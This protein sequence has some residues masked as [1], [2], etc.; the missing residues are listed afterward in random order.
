M[1]KKIEK[2]L[3]TVLFS[4][5]SCLAFTVAA[6]LYNLWMIFILNPFEIALTHFIR[7]D[8]YANFHILLIWAFLTGA[9]VFFNMTRTYKRGKLSKPF[10]YVSKFLM[11]LALVGLAVSVVL[12]PQAY[13]DIH[14]VGSLA[15]AFG[16]IASVVAAFIGAAVK[17]IN[18][19]FLLAFFA[20]IIY[21]CFLFLFVLRQMAAW[22]ILPL[23]CSLFMML[24]WNFTDLFITKDK[25]A[26][27]IKKEFSFRKIPANGL[28]GMFALVAAVVIDF[29]Y[30]EIGASFL[31]SLVSLGRQ[32]A[33]GIWDFEFVW[34]LVTGVAVI[35]ALY[36]FSY[37]S[38]SVSRGFF[39]EIFILV[40]L[41]VLVLACREAWLIWHSG[42]GVQSVYLMY[43]RSFTILSFGILA[44]RL[45]NLSF[46]NI[47]YTAITAAYLFTVALHVVDVVVIKDFPLGENLPILSFLTLL[48]LINYTETF[49]VTSRSAQKERTFAEKDLLVRDT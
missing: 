17:N 24:I 32:G 39:M 33:Y 7:D 48:T 44:F 6:L 38:R 13:D 28:F 14:V 46:K 45:L 1:D 31:P 15:F 11:Y 4:D 37:R 41:A 26:P 47:K 27:K 3:K 49:D 8:N 35:T 9:A 10:L 25:N 29:L 22:E 30:V 20:F 40:D 21:H 34:R 16:M 5:V 12:V 23:L 2:T 42:A 19:L 36:R 18:Y 43:S